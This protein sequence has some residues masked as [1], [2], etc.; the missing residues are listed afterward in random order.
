MKRV[1]VTW[2]RLN[3]P[4]IGHQKLIE[5]TAKF[6]RRW[7]ADYYIFA[8]HT[9]D[10]KK[11]PLK[12]DKKV[13]WMKKMFPTHAD[14]IIY[15][16]S[17]NVIEKMLI[18]IQDMGYDEIAWVAGSDRVPEYRVRWAET[19]NGKNYYFPYFKIVSAGE[20]DPD[21]DGASGM[22]ASKMREAAINIQTT[23]FK[24]GIP[25]TLTDTEKL[26]LMQDVRNGLGLK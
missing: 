5:K 10:K 20:R 11:N 22:S 13:E 1:V 19:Y 7:G 14:H 12:S 26:Q 9:V 4:T 24:S 3:P 23:K 8:T 2:G 18:Y 6:A 17:I 25:D 16:P 21:A 15:D